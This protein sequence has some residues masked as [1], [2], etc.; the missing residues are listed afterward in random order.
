MLL[1]THHIAQYLSIKNASHTRKLD[2]SRVLGLANRAHHTI[3][4]L[5]TSV[6]LFRVDTILRGKGMP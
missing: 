4:L 5:A 1:V 2:S 6:H 3:G